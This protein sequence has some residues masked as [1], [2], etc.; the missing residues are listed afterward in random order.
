MKRIRLDEDT[1]R[2]LVNEGMVTIDGTTLNFT[3]MAM[4][5]NLEK[6]CEGE[7][8]EEEDAEVIL[9]DIGYDRI[10]GILMGRL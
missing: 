3:A 6:L 8:I 7:M 9:A 1:F 4:N 10:H 2:T 5:K